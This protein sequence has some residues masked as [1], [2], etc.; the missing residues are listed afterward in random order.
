MTARQEL[1][2]LEKMSQGKY[3]V[4]V[5]VLYFDMA[6]TVKARLL[7][8]QPACEASIGL[9]NDNSFVVWYNPSRCTWNLSQTRRA[10]YEN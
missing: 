5:N 1:I 7:K 10:K 2:D 9:L 3:L 4:W 8:E 6:K